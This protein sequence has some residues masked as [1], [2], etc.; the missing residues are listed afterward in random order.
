MDLMAAVPQ[1]LRRKA[2][3]FL[4]NRGIAPI[5]SRD[6]VDTVWIDVG[7][8]SGED[9]LDAALANRR[10]LVFA[11]EPNWKVAAQIMARAANFV[12]LPMA[13]S[14]TDGM[15][16]FF[17]NAEEQSSSL[18]EIDERNAWRGPGAPADIS[19]SAEVFV[20]TIRLDTFMAYADLRTVDYLKI[21]AEGAD[22]RIIQ[23]AG[24]RLKDIRQI[25]TE[26]EVA[27]NRAYKGSA[28]REDM[29]SFMSD[30]GFRLTATESQ[31]QGRQQNLT[32]SRE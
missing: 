10:L 15:A 28:S 26:V 31:N 9:T 32:F 22:F 6:L 27:A 2:A 30:Q 3:Q 7:A 14:D 21:D 18:C 5:F 20:P 25:K 16:K 1:R 29:I 19:V 11:F 13:V 23:S 24:E 8:H 4:R 17:I 12:V